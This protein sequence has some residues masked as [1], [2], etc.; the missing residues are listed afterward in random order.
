LPGPDSSGEIFPDC[1][2]PALL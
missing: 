2:L 1:W